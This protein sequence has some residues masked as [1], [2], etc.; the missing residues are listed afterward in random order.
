MNAQSTFGKPVA[1]QGF[2]LQSPI[3]NI[4]IC[5]SERSKESQARDVSLPS[6]WQDTGWIL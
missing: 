5:H 1:R 4:R 6:T 2:K 3:V